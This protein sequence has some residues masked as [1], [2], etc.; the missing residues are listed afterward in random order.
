MFTQSDRRAGPFAA[1]AVEVPALAARAMTRNGAQRG[2]G[3]CTQ[4]CPSPG[5]CM[6]PAPRSRCGRDPGLAADPSASMPDRSTNPKKKE[7]PRPPP[8]PTG[9]PSPPPTP[10]SPPTPTTSPP[11]T[12][13][14]PPH[15]RRHQPPKERDKR[16]HTPPPHT[17]RKKHHNYPRPTAHRFQRA[18]CSGGVADTPRSGWRL[19]DTPAR[20]ARSC[21]CEPAQ[22]QQI[23]RRGGRSRASD[24]RPPSPPLPRPGAPAAHLPL[25]NGAD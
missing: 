10:W 6:L 8:P 11:Q 12:P 24:P 1:R 23:T 2:R 9:T 5:A 7:H 15:P 13:P 17:R 19:V 20:C 16:N 21:R 18:L 25:S 4:R 22:R 14:N 3:V